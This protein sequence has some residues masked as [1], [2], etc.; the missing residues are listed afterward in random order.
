MDD[1]YLIQLGKHIVKLR[2]VKGMT[3]ADLSRAADKDSP[4]INRLEK[5]KINPSVTYLKEIAEALG[6]T[7][8]E[9]LDF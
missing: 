9:L 1:K 8:S 3:Q 7:V 4:S 6:I 2:E 5:G